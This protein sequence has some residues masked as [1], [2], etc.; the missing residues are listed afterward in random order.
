[1]LIAAPAGVLPTQEAYMVDGLTEKPPEQ[2]RG[3]P[4]PKGQSGNPAGRRFGSRNKAT[5]AAQELLADE[6]EALTRKAVEAALAGD[7]TAMRLCL[8]RIL[9]RER[10]V[11]FALPSIK[12]AADVARAMGAVTASLAGGLITPGEAQAIARVVTTFVQMI[13]TSD[14]DRRLQMVEARQAQHPSSPPGVWPP[15]NLSI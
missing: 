4:F 14:F 10:A 9:P 15:S 3:R 5:M 12:S 11:K 13:E 2:V 8:D 1:M 6:A 7:P